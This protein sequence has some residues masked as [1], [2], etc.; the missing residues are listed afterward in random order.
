MGPSVDLTRSPIAMAP[1]KEDWG[2]KEGEGEGKG[3]QS[4]G[5]RRKGEGEG[6]GRKGEGEFF[7]E[8]TAAC[9]HVHD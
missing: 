1:T 5:R 6:E 8:V 2:E 4:E 7:L 9:T 3:R